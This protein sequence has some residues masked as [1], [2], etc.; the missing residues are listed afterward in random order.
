MSLV[1]LRTDKDSDDGGELDEDLGEERDAFLS[2]EEQRSSNKSP[3]SSLVLAPSTSVSR[4]ALDEDCEENILEEVMLPNPVLQAQFRE[5][6]AASGEQG[7]FVQP[8]I[9]FPQLHWSKFKKKIKKFNVS[10]RR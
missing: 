2:G 5:A 3:S 4:E 10:Q 8:N 6:N 1:R 9:K 7:W